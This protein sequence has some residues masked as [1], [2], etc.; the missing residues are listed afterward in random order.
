MCITLKNGTT[1]S[2]RDD[3]Q[4]NFLGLDCIVRDKDGRVD[5][6]VKNLGWLLKHWSDVVGFE[7]RHPAYTEPGYC[8]RQHKTDTVCYMV[9][10]LQDGRTFETNWAD[11]SICR[12]W[13]RR[14]RFRGMDLIWYGERSSC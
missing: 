3:W 10:H 4:D 1:I 9:A 7:I 6:R 11:P 2:D 13:I 5:R 14:P 12:D 8:N